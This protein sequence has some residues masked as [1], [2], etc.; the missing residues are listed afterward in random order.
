LNLLRLT[1]VLTAMVAVSALSLSGAFAQATN[2][3]ALSDKIVVQASPSPVPAAAP[4]SE[5]KYRLRI[6]GDTNLSIIDQNYIGSGLGQ[7]ENPAFISGL[8]FAPGMPYDFFSNAPTASG[9]GLGQNIKLNVAYGPGAVEYGVTL[10]FGSVA[11]SAQTVGYWGEQPIATINPHLGQT[12]YQLPVAFPTKPGLDDVSGVRGSVLGGFIQTKDGNYALNVGWLD[13]KQTQKFV[14]QQA[15]VTNSSPALAVVPPNSIGPGAPT[16]EDWLPSNLQLPV[17]GGDAYAKIGDFS[18]E[19]TVGSLPAPAGV[20]VR[21]NDAS[22]MW[23]QPSGTK[24][25]LQYSN[26]HTG[27]MPISSTTFFGAPIVTG[28]GTAGSPCAIPTGF[29]PA[30]APVLQ[31]FPGI[32]TTTS[33]AITS[34]SNFGQGPIPFTC[35]NGQQNQIWGASG[36]GTL[37]TFVD[38]LAEFGYS[39][40]STAVGAS[41]STV[42]TWFHGG[43]TQHVGPIALT[44]DYYSVDPRYAPTILPY[45]NCCNPPNTTENIWSAAYTWPAQWL[46]GTYQSVDDTQAYNNRRGFKFGADYESDLIQA[47][48]KYSVLS[49]IYPVTL[50]TGAQSG[51]VEGYYLPELVTT[52][53]NLGIDRQFAV[54]LGL[55]PKVMDVS[56]DYVTQNNYRPGGISP[57]SAAVG[58]AIDTVAMNYPQMSI[59]LS[60]HLSEKFLLAGGYSNFQVKGTWA[61]SGVNMNQGVTFVGFQFYRSQ[62]MQLLM[63]ARWYNTQGAPPLT[64]T[65]APTLKGLQFIFEQKAKI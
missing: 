2:W 12:S 54:W 13:L 43:L 60:R 24:F 6:S 62:G 34:G 11:G 55:H 58:S 42:G 1:G 59:T 5:H 9:F 10:G 15:P 19:A 44:E 41:G 4:P 31:P 63:Q 65:I 38:G 36:S 17:S 50:A 14:F 45:G 40:Y 22:V 52:G 46:R 39:Q 7:L 8:P 35:L 53:G 3:Q 21:L 25:G 64:D 30:G 16:L 48:V 29:S 27:G 26:I 47:K 32:I 56:L 23:N 49:Q 33:G 61:G 28:A 37:F 20:G 57:V 18:L 51:F